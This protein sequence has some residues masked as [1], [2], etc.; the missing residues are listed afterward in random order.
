MDSVSSTS[1]ATTQNSQ[2]TNTQRKTTLTQADFM[3]LLLKQLQYQDP[4]A[5]MDNYQMASQMAQFESVQ[6][7]NDITQ[8]L[9]NQQASNSLQEIGLIGKK[10]EVKGNSLSIDGSGVV[11]G[12]SYQLASPGW[13]YVQIFDAH[14]NIVRIID[15]GARDTSKQT[16]TW[17][18]KDQ[19]GNQLPAGNYTFQVS[20]VDKTNQSIQVSTSSIGTVTGISFEGGVTYLNIGPG[21]VNMSDIIAITA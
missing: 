17:D 4:L 15:Q 10:V 5:P 3:N 2:A 13:A 19:Q 8:L 7:L 6:S 18:G 1:S 21:K 12:G 9:Q 11:S 14:G 20:A 16:F